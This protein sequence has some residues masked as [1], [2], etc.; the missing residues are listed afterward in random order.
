MT[1]QNKKLSRRDAIKL[2]GAAV[3]AA[4]LANLPTKWSKP[5]LV[6]GVLPAHAQTSVLCTEYAMIAEIISRSGNVGFNSSLTPPTSS[7][8]TIGQ[9]GYTLY[10][11]CTPACIMVYAY[12]NTGT[13]IT[14][15][16]TVMGSVLP[17]VVLT[18][19]GVGVIYYG[20]HLDASTGLYVTTTDGDYAP[21]VGNCPAYED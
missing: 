1:E 9:V 16:F 8:G 15:R 11:D 12:A 21:P 19:G 5:S 14:V 2:L 13:S 10:W 18:Q 17:D 6:S 3:G 7:S 20:I 4:T